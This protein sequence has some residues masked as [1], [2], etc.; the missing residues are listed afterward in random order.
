VRALWLACE[1]H[2]RLWLAMPG[3]MGHKPRSATAPCA[4]TCRDSP[5]SPPVRHRPARQWRGVSPL[6]PLSPWGR[7]GSGPVRHRSGRV[8]RGAWASR[9][10][11]VPVTAVP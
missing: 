10:H 2:P 11:Q 7:A 1:L 3:A 8:S 4:H 5:H 9:Y 6:S